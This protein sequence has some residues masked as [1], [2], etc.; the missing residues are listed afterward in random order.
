MGLQLGFIFSALKA[1]GLKYGTTEN[2][3]YDKRLR[4]LLENRIKILKKNTKFKNNRR[5][6]SVNKVVI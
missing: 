6:K 2:P 4:F 5:E 3:Y 1:A